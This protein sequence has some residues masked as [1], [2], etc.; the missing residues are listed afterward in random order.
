MKDMK[1]G[2][3]VAV[4]LLLSC[5]LGFTSLYTPQ[6][7]D[8]A[9]T[10]FS[11][12][13]AAKDIEVIAKE[14]H[15]V[16]DPEALRE[17]R[18]YLI[19]RLG[20]LGLESEVFTYE[21]ITDKYGW[22]YDINNIYTKLDGKDGED[23]TYIMLVAHYDSSPAK[24]LG[25]TGGS[26]GAADD[27]YG[28]ATILEVVR[29]IKESGKPLENGI[30]I[31]ITDAEETGL[32]GAEKEMTMN[33]ALYEN[34]SFVINLEARGIKGP[35]IMF[36][37]SNQNLEVI[38]LFKAANLPVSYSLA[39]D[40]YRKM[41]NGTDFTHFINNGLAGINIA[42]L[43]NLDYYHTPEDNYDNISLISLQHYGEQ[44]LPIVE[45]FVYDGKYG[46]KDALKA[47]ENGIFFTLLPNVMFLYSHTVGVILAVVAGI[48]LL[49]TIFL[50]IRTAQMKVIQVV[51]WIGAWLGIA[52][53]MAALGFGI[54][55]LISIVCDMPLKLTYMP[56]VPG[57]NWIVLGAVAVGALLVSLLLLWRVKKGASL[58]AIVLGGQVLQMVLLILFMVVLSGGSFLF[59][60][61][62]I[63]TC[64][65]VLG[66]IKGY[67]WM[68]LIP[69]CMTTIMFVPILYVLNIALT[70]GA[71]VV[72]MLLASFAMTTIIPTVLIYM[73]NK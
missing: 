43:D 17:V 41:P 65:A 52:V 44:V 38:K 16:N 32:I 47:D 40:V 64:L 54:T 36:E 45:T 55:K 39:A 15:T 59:L 66:T 24:R 46:D 53:V 5:I 28:L 21:D 58:E 2:L 20:E 18:E 68:V 4:V 42:V 1:K 69:A 10:G 73:K 9:H 26:K 12:E 60:W 62:L 67:K 14:P 49:G 34:V 8:E 50:T 51:K 6:V 31:L 35:A 3:V 30:K 48:L 13:R 61:P 56:K 37:T 22:T 27:G 63:F 25:E 19:K 11:A 72:M 29:A 33:K 71:L 23:G 70:I 7:K 57:A